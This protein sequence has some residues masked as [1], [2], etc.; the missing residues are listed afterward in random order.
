[1]K[2]KSFSD[3]DIKV[4]R[5]MSY[6][7]ALLGVFGLVMA[8]I[9]LAQVGFTWQ[10]AGLLALAVG[11]FGDLAVKL[12]LW[13]RDTLNANTFWSRM[14]LNIIALVIAGLVVFVVLMLTTKAFFNI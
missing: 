7:T 11:T 2:K 6:I 5:Q 4:Q 14:S 12:L 1:M 10:N 8:C 13:Q 3:R 9:P